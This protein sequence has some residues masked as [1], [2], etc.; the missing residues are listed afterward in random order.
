MK[1]TVVKVC[2]CMECMLM[3]SSDIHEHVEDLKMDIISRDENIKDDDIVI[4]AITKC[5]GKES[6]TGKISPVVSVNDEV[7][8]NATSQIVMEKVMENYQDEV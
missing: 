5:H 8:N 7:I 6:E 3:G 1:K 2:T 4:E